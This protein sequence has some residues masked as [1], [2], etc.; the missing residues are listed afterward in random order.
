MTQDPICSLCQGPLVREKS[1]TIQ[2]GGSNILSYT[3][4]WVCRHCSAAFPIAT[5]KGGVIREAQPLYADGKR[6]R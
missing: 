6:T 3:L 4:A 2:A 5:G 1:V